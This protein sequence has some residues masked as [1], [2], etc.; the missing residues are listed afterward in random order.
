TRS[1]RL[2]LRRQRWLRSGALALLYC[3]AVTHVPRRDPTNA[4]MLCF[5]MRHSPVVCLENLVI[6]YGTFT[7]VDGLSF[8]LRTGELFG[9]LGPN[10]AGKS[11]TLR[12]LIGQQRPSAGTVTVFG[13]DIVH[14]WASIKPL[15]GYVPDCENHFE[16]F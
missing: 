7:A 10:G 1:P 9:L 4:R 16:E 13:Q 2:K 14:Q 3:R 8:E 5:F 15:F 6:R 12:V 11:S